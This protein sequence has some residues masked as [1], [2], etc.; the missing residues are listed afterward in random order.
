MRNW[1]PV[2]VSQLAVALRVAG[3]FGE[4][5]SSM[6]APVPI[7]RIGMFISAAVG[8]MERRNAAQICGRGVF[9]ARVNLCNWRGK[10]GDRMASATVYHIACLVDAS[11]GMVWGS[12]KV[13]DNGWE[14]WL[15]RGSRS[16]G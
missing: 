13:V 5:G 15:L 4:A 1:N 3:T 8:R 6:M 16:S 2:R 9:R 7:N 11:S 12:E 14:S 10:V